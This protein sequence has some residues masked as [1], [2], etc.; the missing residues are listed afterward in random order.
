MPGTEQWSNAWQRSSCALPASFGFVFRRNQMDA[1]QPRAPLYIFSMTPF[2]QTMAKHMV[3]YKVWLS[4]VERGLLWVKRG[5]KR[6]QIL[7]D[8]RRSRRPWVRVPR[9]EFEWTGP[10]AA[11]D[12]QRIQGDVGKM[13]GWGRR[14]R[15][16]PLVSSTKTGL[17]GALLMGSTGGFQRQTNR[18]GQSLDLSCPHL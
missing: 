6:K 5:V 12:A 1:K 14:G 15:G 2:W 16:I 4:L 18:S 17:K 10:V 9:Q 8:L 11:Q 3:V 13:D 7:G